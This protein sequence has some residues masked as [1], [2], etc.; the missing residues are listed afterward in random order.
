MGTPPCMSHEIDSFELDS[1][2]PTMVVG[3]LDQMSSHVVRVWVLSLAFW[4]KVLGDRHHWLLSPCRY[5]TSMWAVPTCNRQNLGAIPSRLD[6]QKHLDDLLHSAGKAPLSF[7]V[8]GYHHSQRMHGRLLELAKIE[9]G[10]AVVINTL[11]LILNHTTA[12]MDI[13][14]TRCPIFLVGWLIFMHLEL[15]LSLALSFMRTSQRWWT[16]WRNTRKAS[17]SSTWTRTWNVPCNAL[18]A[19]LM[20]TSQALVCGDDAAVFILLFHHAHRL[21]DVIMEPGVSGRNRWRCINISELARKIGPQVSDISLFGVLWFRIDQ[22]LLISTVLPISFPVMSSSGYLLCVHWL[23]LYNT[24]QWEGREHAFLADDGWS[25]SS[26]CF[27][28]SKWDE[29]TT[30][31][32]PLQDENCTCTLYSS[33]DTRVN[34]SHLQKLLS[35]QIKK[36]TQNVATCEEICSSLPITMS[37]CDK[38]NSSESIMAHIWKYAHLD[39]TTCWKPVEHGWKFFPLWSNATGNALWRWWIS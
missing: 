30:R 38:Q 35:K 11:W 29:I 18:A 15:F 31:F 16:W 3:R 9:M 19:T 33:N 17:A 37:G 20:N 13:A 10:T 26:R 21:C 36:R 27:Y 6:A 7:L 39:N 23:W 12:N 8:E 1:S 25:G 28:T 4:I 14:L 34:D 32:C 24:I 2:Q 22:R 5:T